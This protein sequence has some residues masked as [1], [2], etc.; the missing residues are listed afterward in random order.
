MKLSAYEYHN[1]HIADILDTED[2]LVFTSQTK[3]GFS[4]PLDFIARHR[5]AFMLAGEGEVKLPPPRYR[6]LKEVAQHLFKI[7][8]GP[9][10]TYVIRNVPIYKAHPDTRKYGV[11]CDKKFLDRMVKNF[12]ATTSATAE[13]FGTDRH[14][15][16]PKIHY[17]HT[18]D[19]PDVEERECA[20]FIDSPYR[21]D[22]FLFADYIGLDKSSL[23]QLV[24][25]RYPDRS[26]EVD[27]RRARLLSVA[28]L[29]YRTP[30]FALPQMT[31]QELRQQYLAVIQKNAASV[32]GVE[33]C[34]FLEEDFGMPTT[35]RNIRKQEPLTPEL[36]AKFFMKMAEDE[37]LS[38]MYDTALAKHCD[39]NGGAMPQGNALMQMIQQVMQQMMSQKMNSA[40]AGQAGQTGQQGPAQ[41]SLSDLL[42]LESRAHHS[43]GEEDL[44]EEGTETADDAASE[45]AD[46]LEDGQPS[47]EG[48]DQDTVSPE[49]KIVKKKSAG[50]I[51][52][53]K[54]SLSRIADSHVRDQ[55]SAVLE[56]MGGAVEA[57]A[58]L[59]ERQHNALE[60]LTKEV[61]VQK[62]ARRKQSFKSRFDKM[63]EKGNPNARNEDQVKKHMKLLLS[64][65]EEDAETYISN[66]EAAPSLPV[67]RHVARNEIIEPGDTQDIFERAKNALDKNRGLKRSGV[68][69]EHLAALDLI[70]SMQMSEDEID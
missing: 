56:D 63:F 20:G 66:L 37:K 13:L 17:G 35:K 39:M 57:Q 11:T 6:S 38:A 60:T 15:W 41:Y 30:H 50:L 69:A 32:Q 4:V 47:D 31:P 16:R 46:V 40:P 26:A 42:D 25:G 24:S 62:H 67:S 64:L 5:S 49:G 43:A 7:E 44:D 1:G 48:V 54:N 23:D 33:T 18:P 29:G 65:G 58:S 12:Y 19:D 2:G 55:L 8:N 27:L 70:D 68:K 45:D 14:G 3:K 36:V 61:M 52:K 28:V 34:V 10:G 21:I 22:D 9:K 51:Q 59:I 53:A